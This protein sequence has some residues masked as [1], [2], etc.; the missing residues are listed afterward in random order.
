LVPAI[1]SL[2]KDEGKQ[3]EL[4]RNISQLAIANADEIIASNIVNSIL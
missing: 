4:K 2:S 3:E 1:I